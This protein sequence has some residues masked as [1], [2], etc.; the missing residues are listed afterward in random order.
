MQEA[1]ANKHKLPMETLLTSC[2]QQTASDQMMM[3]IR[4]VC[5]AGLLLEPSDNIVYFQTMLQEAHHPCRFVLAVIIT[6]AIC[7]YFDASCHA[8]LFSLLCCH[9]WVSGIVIATISIFYVSA[10]AGVWTIVSQHAYCKWEAEVCLPG[11]MMS[12]P[13][14]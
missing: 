6:D 9:I 4:A 2:R 11:M 7:L 12:A 1:V 14:A 13:R 10:A 8:L 3:F 5:A